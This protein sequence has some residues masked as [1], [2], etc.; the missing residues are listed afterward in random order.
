LVGEPNRLTAVLLVDDVDV[1]RLRPGQRAQLRIDQLPGQVIPGEVVE[2]ARREVPNDPTAGGQADL[3]A[4]SAGLVPPGGRSAAYYPVR[5]RFAPPQQPL[6][7][8]GRG[9]AK[10]AAERITLARSIVRFLGRTFRL[11][12]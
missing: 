7:I 8:G 4:L 2:V 12:M 1:E 9:Q 10:V 5:V 6:V 11:P 3:A